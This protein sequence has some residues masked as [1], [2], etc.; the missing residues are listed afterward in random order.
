MLKRKPKR[1][2]HV[3]CYF[4]GWGFP[5]TNLIIV[6]SIEQFD[7]SA[8]DAVCF[9]PFDGDRIYIQYALFYIPNAIML[10]LIIF[11]VGHILVII[12]KSRF[13]VRHIKI[14]ANSIRPFAKVVHVG[15]TYLS[16]WLL[17]LCGFFSITSNRDEETAALL[18][19]IQCHV[20]AYVQD[21]P[22]PCGDVPSE[23][24]N[25]RVLEA[26][27]VGMSFHGI[28]VFFLFCFDRDLYSG[29]VILYERA[30]GKEMAKANGNKRRTTSITYQ[31]GREIG[32]RR[33]SSVA[34]AVR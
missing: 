34:V 27:F 7:F 6:L 21:I 1:R 20:M 22:Y 26:F 25:L 18:E 15:I 3:F 14:Q 32:D 2:W 12:S 23:R 30:T 9:L 5:L 31:E 28:L 11:M 33:R 24:P 16:V 4:Y 19:W 10:A 13:R 8:P 29:W 17:V